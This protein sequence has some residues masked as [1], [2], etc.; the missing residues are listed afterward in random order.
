MR[1]GWASFLLGNTGNCTAAGDRGG[2]GFYDI[3]TA[4]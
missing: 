3:V 1:I 4:Y 2:A